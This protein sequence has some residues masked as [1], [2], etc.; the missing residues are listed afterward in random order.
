MADLDE[1]FRSL[2][3]V[4][5]PDLWAEIEGREPREPRLEPP[6]RRRWVVAAVALAVA[7]AGIALAIRAFPTG[8]PKGPLPASPSLGRIAF[9]WYHGSTYQIYTANAD[10]T[11]LLQV[12][13]MP[14]S[15]VD[16]TWSP[17]GTRI[18]FS[19]ETVPGEGGR[20]DIYIANADGTAVTRLTHGPDSYGHP[21]WSPDGGMIAA[22]RWSAGDGRGDVV[23][24]PVNGAAETVLTRGRPGDSWSPVW[25]PDGTKLAYVS[26][27]DAHGSLNDDI[28]VINVD[29]TGPTDLTNSPATDRDPTWSK[30]DQ[31]A[32]FGGSEASPG[33]YG[34]HADGTQVREL[35]PNVMEGGDPAWSPDGSTIAFIENAYRLGTGRV[36]LFDPATGSVTH[37]LDLVGVASPSWEPGP[38]GLTTP[39]SSS[40]TRCVVARTSGDFDG[41]GTTDQAQFVDLVRGHVSC[42]NP[43]TVTSHV[44]S[45]E[46]VVRFGS[47]QTLD[48]PFTGCQSSCAQSAFEATDLAGDGR[49]ELAIDVGLGAAIDFI[50]FFR[51]DQS[52][53]S[54]LLIAEPGDPPYVKPGP[55]VIGG[56]FDS[57]SQSPVAC[58]VAPDG[59]RELVAVAAENTGSR[60]DGPWHIHTTT[61]ILKGDRLQVR[62]SSD[63]QGPFPMTSKIFDN[64]CPDGSAATYS[65]WGAPAGSIR[66]DVLT[67]S[68]LRP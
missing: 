63:T 44:Q 47:G 26:N 41:D 60:V 15:V 36:A 48:Q 27:R 57:G 17:D 12:T 19:G 68:A 33:L 51:V 35:L 29:G 1:R 2:A 50:Q 28:W 37:P 53:I 40:V 9:A 25:S 62:S 67:R 10:G 24:L 45:R 23:L 56:G 13:H 59:T 43:A 11:D 61:M 38:A 58:R 31:I 18:A 20:T 6:S 54:P 42:E 39:P 3:R 5:P 46:I 21:S 16:P 52:G 65:S 30:G 34:M 22:S 4:R 55:A 49:Y 64:G 7:A 66:A 32:F 14:I 8:S